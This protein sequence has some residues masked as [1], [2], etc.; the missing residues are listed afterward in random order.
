MKLGWYARR[1]STMGPRE[2]AHRFAEQARRAGFRRDRRGWKRFAVGDGA[3][4]AIPTLSNAFR[5]NWPGILANQLQAGAD[6]LSAG[7]LTLLGQT[8]PRELVR[9]LDPA[10]WHFDPETGGRWPGRETYCF[11][12]DYRSG[13]GLG[14]VKFVWELNRLQF[15]QPVAALSLRRGDRAL[16]RWA[17]DAVSS[18]MDANPPF[19]GVNWASG[20]ELG[21]R[22]V[23][24]AFVVA[25]AGT[26]LDAKARTRLRSFVAAHGFWLARYPSLYSSANN[27]RVAEG[28]GLLV[29][30]LIA[31]DLPQA[32]SWCNLGRRILAA[33][34]FSQFHADGT[35]KEQSP[36]YA[37]FVLEMLAFAA[38]NDGVGLFTAEAQERI[39][40]AARQL[41]LMV[42]GAGVP[43]RIGDDD[44][45][46]VVAVSHARERRYVASIAAAI[47]GVF[48]IAD[49]TWSRRD[50]HFRDLVFHSPEAVLAPAPIGVFHY[51]KGGYTIVR[52]ALGGR[53]IVLTFD[54]GPLG[55]TPLAAHGH[56]DALAVWLHVG[57][58][59]VIIDAGTG[60]YHA[61]GSLREQMRSSFA[62]NTL[63]V[64]DESQSLTAGPFNWRH[65]ARTQIV[66]FRSGPDWSVTARHDGYRRRFGV[67]H[68]RTLSHAE[69]GFLIEDGLVGR[70]VK[71][72]SVVAAFLIHPS[73]AVSIEDGEAVIR[74]EDGEVRIA[75]SGSKAELIRGKRPWPSLYSG[76]FGETV[77]ATTILLP[78]SLEPGAVL[79]TEVRIRM[80]HARGSS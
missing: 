13:Q 8:W 55:F 36:T 61:G 63:I 77:P 72:L 47:A 39:A 62:H 1:L 21:L 18:W 32:T 48:G 78:G 76:W 10:M 52:E 5:D 17:L 14:D 58:Q 70:A 50:A 30:G 56:A 68:E 67:Y 80:A 38:V 40:A 79:R 29:A 27:H 20:I 41:T 53:G 11:D 34:P 54:H 51:S 49:L 74:L 16:A 7:T 24:L 59:P 69:G 4:V 15:L 26:A 46:R 64:G 33:T 57:A 65:K 43:P 25:G 37:A 23:S 3:L 73:L 60:L 35:G 28:L 75:T 71:P 42:D 31:P 6:A 22:L 2:I 66:D 45:G 19:R 44:E 12:V 9:R